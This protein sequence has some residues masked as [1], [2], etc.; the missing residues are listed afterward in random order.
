MDANICMCECLCLEKWSKIHY[1]EIRSTHRFGQLLFFCRFANQLQNT[2]N[3]NAQNLANG[4]N[5]KGR[6]QEGETTLHN[7]QGKSPFFQYGQK[8]CTKGFAM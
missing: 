1:T 8:V 6:W 2:Q 4:W 7:K 3:V 5:E